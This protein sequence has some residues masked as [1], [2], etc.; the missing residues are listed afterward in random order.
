VTPAL[1][2]RLSW[3]AVVGGAGAANPLLLYRGSSYL[4][5]KFT[6][7]NRQP[8]KIAAEPRDLNQPIRGRLVARHTVVEHQERARGGTA[9]QGEGGGGA[10]GEVGGGQQGGDGGFAEG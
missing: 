7:Q 1:A 6:S 9:P 4:N 2:N 10:G 8:S 3:F 5:T